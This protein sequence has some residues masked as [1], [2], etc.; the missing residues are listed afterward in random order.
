[1]CLEILG[2]ECPFHWHSHHILKD[3][4]LIY[5][6]L[7][8]SP[9]LKDKDCMKNIR[10]YR[11]RY[12]WKNVHQLESRCF[13]FFVFHFFGIGILHFS[14]LRVFFSGVWCWDLFPHSSCFMLPYVFSL[15]PH[16]HS[17]HI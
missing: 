3:D 8:C 2:L 13:L 6:R 7:S 15:M 16:V 5:G 12:T 9:F 4:I 14:N 17:M 11:L 1:M 10:T